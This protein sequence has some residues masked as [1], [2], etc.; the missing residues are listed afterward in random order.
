VS[1]R[2]RHVLVDTQGLLLEVAVH[3]ASVQERAGGETL[4]ARAKARPSCGRLARVWADGGYDGEPFRGWVKET[5]GW[6]LEVVAKPPDRKGFAV[7]PRRWVVERSFGRLGRS[8]RLSKDYEQAPA[9]EEAFVRL[10][11]TRL[12]LRRLRPGSTD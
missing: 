7:L 5:C 6:E 12:M 1:G 8:R 11:M 4:L 2:K 9:S 3:A 10:A